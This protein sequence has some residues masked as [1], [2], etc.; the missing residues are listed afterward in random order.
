MLSERLKGVFVKPS[1]KLH[2]GLERERSAAETLQEQGARLLMTNLRYPGGEIDLIV[3]ERDP[4]TGA[5][6]LVFVEVRARRLGAWFRGIESVDQRKLARLKI[7]INR[8]LVRYGGAAKGVRLDLMVWDGTA[9][10]RFK[11]VAFS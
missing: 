8:F 4:T 9:W 6:V 2:Y 5:W 11:D 7:G 1:E 3:E 10:T